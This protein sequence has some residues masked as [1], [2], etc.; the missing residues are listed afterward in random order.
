MKVAVQ[1]KVLFSA[2]TLLLEIV[3]DIYQAG[4]TVPTI[5]G[6]IAREVEH[7]LYQQLSKIESPAP[8]PPWE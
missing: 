8:T 6:S 1:Q 7:L 5:A 2:H 3:L 4:L